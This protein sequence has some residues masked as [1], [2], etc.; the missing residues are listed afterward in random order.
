MH[1]RHFPIDDSQSDGVAY[2]SL[3]MHERLYARGCI[4][5]CLVWCSFSCTATHT[6]YPLDTYA[7]WLRTLHR[8]PSGSRVSVLSSG[9]LRD[10]CECVLPR[11]CGHFGSHGI[12]RLLALCLP[13]DFQLHGVP[14]IYRRWF[15]LL[16]YSLRSQSVGERLAH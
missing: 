5:S 15:R 8:A 14:D 13:P 1:Y 9:F 6:P 3:H 2:V 12:G 11:L 4:S 16:V 7:V 10:L